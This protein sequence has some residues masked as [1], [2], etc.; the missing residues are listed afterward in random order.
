[1]SPLLR[2]GA[3]TNIPARWRDPER[4]GAGYRTRT[5]DPLITNFDRPD[6]GSAAEATK[7]LI[8]LKLNQRR[9]T[10]VASVT[11]LVGNLMGA[12]T[13]KLVGVVVTFIAF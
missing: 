1:M 3:L 4:T 9:V 13:T 5:Y 11:V 10:P 6:G 8:F 12:E 7:L 2:H